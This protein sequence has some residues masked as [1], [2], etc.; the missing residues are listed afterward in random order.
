MPRFF[1]FSLLL[2]SVLAASLWAG[3]EPVRRNAAGQAGGTRIAPVVME[4]SVSSAGKASSPRAKA[5]PRRPIASARAQAPSESAPV[6]SVAAPVASGTGNPNDYILGVRARVLSALRESW[7]A[8][9]ARRNGLSGRVILKLVLN[10]HGAAERTEIVQSSGFAQLDLLATSAARA[11]GPFPKPDSKL[12]RL[13]TF[14]V[15]VP[16]E[17]GAQLQ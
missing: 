1:A 8:D 15:V 14:G 12:A 3:L 5:A 4:T 13:G 6:G 10:E 7:N 9:E 17:F 16:I 2:H 11:A